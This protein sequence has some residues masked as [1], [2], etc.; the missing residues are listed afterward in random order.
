MRAERLVQ[1][2]FVAAGY[3]TL[4]GVIQIVHRAAPPRFGNKAC[5]AASICSRGALECLLKP[6]SETALSDALNA[7]L[8]MR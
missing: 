3:R 6:F 2:R 4:R 5:V 1:R 7:V 8:R